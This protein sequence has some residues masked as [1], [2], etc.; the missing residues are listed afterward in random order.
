MRYLPVSLDTY[1]KKILILGGGYLALSALKSVIDTEAEIYMIADTFTKDIV[2]KSEESYGKIKLKEHELEK[3]FKFMGFDYVLIATEDFELNEALEKRAS[4]RNMIYQRFDIF[5][6]SLMSINKSLE[7]GPLTFSLNS[8]RLNPTI[9]DI[10]FEDLKN[11]VKKYNLEKL[12][13]LSEIRSE[14]VRK[15]SQNID[16]IIRNLY[17]SETINLSTF[18]EEMPEYKIEDLKSSEELINSIENGSN[19][20]VEKESTLEDEQIIKKNLDDAKS[21]SRDK[22]LN[23][24]DLH[25]ES[26]KDLNKF[27]K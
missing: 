7:H 26:F 9:T 8:S 19:I 5:S 6:K 18:L 2:K 17:E 25:L 23:K 11:F 14:L 13:I 16:E 27:E 3:D 24:D 12:N 21:L 15:N 10:V 4:S 20:K 1:E 22:D